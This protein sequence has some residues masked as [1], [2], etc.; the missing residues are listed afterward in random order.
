[1]VSFNIEQYRKLFNSYTR[2]YTEAAAEEEEAAE[3]EVVVVTEEAKI[4]TRGKV[5]SPKV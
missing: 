3:E 4:E 2:I 5:S 1:M